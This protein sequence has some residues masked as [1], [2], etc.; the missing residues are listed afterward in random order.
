MC[1]HTQKP[2]EDQAGQNPQFWALSD[3][4]PAGEQSIQKF[5]VAGSLGDVMGEPEDAPTPAELHLQT[6]TRQIFSLKNDSKHRITE[7]KLEVV[8]FITYKALN[9]NQC[10]LVDSKHGIPLGK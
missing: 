5:H 8:L 9:R 3:L 4:Y 6:G 2:P 7:N 10:S 1:T